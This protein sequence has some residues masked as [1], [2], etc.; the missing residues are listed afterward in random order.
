MKRPNERNL[1]AAQEWLEHASI[2]L[3]YARRGV[4]DRLI[5]GAHVCFHAQQ[6]AEKAIKALLLAHG[7]QFPFT[8]DLETLISVLKSSRIAAP[9]FV[10]RA[11]RLSPYAVQLRYPGDAE[12]DVGKPEV[13][14]AIS[15][16]GKGLAWAA[17]A[18]ER[19]AKST[20]CSTKTEIIPRHAPDISKATRNKKKPNGEKE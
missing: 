14:S 1:R 13:R 12:Q 16:A 9:S 2:D 4:N 5:L 17:R 20:H 10:R 15:L 18:V 7:Q 19:S 6:A 8:H 11:G 3:R